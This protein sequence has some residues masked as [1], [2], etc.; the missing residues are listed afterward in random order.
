MLAPTISYI[1]LFCVGVTIGRPQFRN[2][3]QVFGQSQSLPKSAG[4]D[5]A[6]SAIITIAIPARLTER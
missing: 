2:E 3:I 4:F 6:K 5:Y 1:A